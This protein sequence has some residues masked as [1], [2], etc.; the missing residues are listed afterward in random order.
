MFACCRCRGGLAGLTAWRLALAACWYVLV[1]VTIRLY[2]NMLAFSCTME[3]WWW[4]FGGVFMLW[5]FRSEG[6]LFF[7]CNKAVSHG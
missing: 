1:C 5:T 2:S 7:G 3:F 4:T 6:W